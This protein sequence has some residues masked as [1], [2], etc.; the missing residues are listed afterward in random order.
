M[1]RYTVLLLLP[2]YLASEFGHD[3]HLVWTK[4]KNR[5]SAIR[6]A[7]KFA[8]KESEA[9]EASPDDYH[10]L[11]VCYGHQDNLNNGR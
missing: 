2:D 10:P 11:F 9:L 7:Q 1:R 6:E 4:A 5:A 8:A 3:T